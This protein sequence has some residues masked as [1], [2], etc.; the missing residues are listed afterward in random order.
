MYDTVSDFISFLRCFPLFVV[1]DILLE[2]VD[3][4]YIVGG[5]FVIERTIFDNVTNRK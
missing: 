5:M 4:C 2:K 3:L 1:F